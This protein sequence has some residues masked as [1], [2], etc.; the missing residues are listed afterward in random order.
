[1]LGAEALK[2]AG[3]AGAGRGEDGARGLVVGAAPDPQPREADHRV[4]IGDL[5]RFDPAGADEQRVA[6]SVENDSAVTTRVQDQRV[7]ATR[8]AQRLHGEPRGREVG[9]GIERH[10]VQKLFVGALGFG[11]IALRLGGVTLLDAVVH[12]FEKAEVR[13]HLVAQRHHVA[14]GPETRAVGAHVPAF[15]VGTGLRDCL[16]HL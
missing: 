5:H 7:Q 1:M 3:A 2:P 12:D 11:G 4:D 15:V 6:F 10:A 9:R 14:D 13:A 8:F 16:C